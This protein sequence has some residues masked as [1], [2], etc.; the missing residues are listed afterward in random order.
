MK[1]LSYIA[2]V[3]GFIV[4]VIFVLSLGSFV[5]NIDSLSH[6]NVNLNSSSASQILEVFALFQYNWLI[7]PSIQSVLSELKNNSLKNKLISSII[8]FVGLFIPFLAIGLFNYL[9]YT[10]EPRYL[11]EA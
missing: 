10:T 3:T 6:S 8:T 7:Q 2:I 4:P 1:G 9:E 5:R 11:L